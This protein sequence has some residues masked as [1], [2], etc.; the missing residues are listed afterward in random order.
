M[1][2]V[3]DVAHPLLRSSGMRRTGLALACWAFFRV[4]S[5]HASPNAS[6]TAA[7][8]APWGE[9]RVAQ[10]I[11][12]ATTATRSG[13]LASWSLLSAR[14]TWVQVALLFDARLRGLSHNERAWG[15][16]LGPVWQTT[17]GFRA[18]ALITAGWTHA[19]LPDCGFSCASVGRGYA[20]PHLDGR[21]GVGYALGRSAHFKVLVSAW[22][23]HGRSAERRIHYEEVYTPWLFGGDETR[24]NASLRMGGEYTAAL[25]TLG[26]IVNP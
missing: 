11:G 17:A 6:P 4:H 9:L 8:T 10:G 2:R 12:F 20:E 21:L 18:E 23:V 5:V 1:P 15:A 26:L 24:E 7:P 13:A 22:A 16:G 19:S 3:L 25:A 14:F